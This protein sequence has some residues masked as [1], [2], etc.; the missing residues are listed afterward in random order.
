MLI[1]RR[2]WWG[3]LAGGIL[4]A[5]RATG[6]TAG[7]SNERDEKLRYLL[8]FT[9]YVEWPERKFGSSKDPIVIGILGEDPFGHALDEQA[10][11][12]HGRRPI[13]VRRFKG[14]QQFRS[15]GLPR[16]SRN[17][18]ED[19]QKRKEAELRKCHVLYVSPSEDDFVP[20]I[21]R[22]VEGASVL[23]VG[24]RSS[25]AQPDKREIAGVV[26]LY[27]EG[28]Q[29]RFEINVSQAEKAKLKISSKLRALAKPV[30]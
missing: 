13:E 27:T 22:S 4:A 18:R 17:E 23:T 5:G 9:E 19:Q 25:F 6:G 10:A 20:S 29:L 26:C 11:Q 24:E 16:P 2:A 21:L 30:G 3:G 28:P 1:S 14:W 12:L 15:S 8:L 7:I